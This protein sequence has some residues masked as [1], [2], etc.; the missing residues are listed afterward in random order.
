M[1]RFREHL[2]SGGEMA[3]IEFGDPIKPYAAVW[4]HAT[5]FNA[6]T[7]Q[8]MLAPLGLRARVAA[9]DLR[10]HGRSTLPAKGSLA[11]W[12]KTATT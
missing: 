1:R 2:K 12:N 7:Y 4:L 6:M 3:G 9:L 11:S 8:S 5:G 10:G